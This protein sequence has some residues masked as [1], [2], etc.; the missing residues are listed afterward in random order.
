MD[1]AEALKQIRPEVDRLK[2]GDQIKLV[3][4]ED[5]IRDVPLQNDA[6]AIQNGVLV[7]LFRLFDADGRIVDAF[8]LAVWALFEHRPDVRAFTA[9]AVQDACVLCDLGKLQSPIRERA[10]ADV[11]HREHQLPAKALGLAGIFKKRH[12]FFSFWLT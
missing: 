2:C 1:L 12:A 8:D 6:A 11:H 9:A 4:R 5:E 3:R 7:D 10:M